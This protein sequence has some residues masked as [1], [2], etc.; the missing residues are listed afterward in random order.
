LY[1]ERTAVE[2]VEVNHRRS[3]VPMAEQLLH[4]SNIDSCF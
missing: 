2:Y 3:D 1:A 4:C